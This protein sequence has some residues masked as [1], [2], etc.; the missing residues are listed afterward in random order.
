MKAGKQDMEMA[1]SL[2]P[3]LEGALHTLPHVRKGKLIGEQAK[4]IH[5][6]QGHTKQVEEH[7][8]RRGGE[9]N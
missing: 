9:E 3:E 8:N 1:G 7:Q 6:V 5:R 2:T 4:G